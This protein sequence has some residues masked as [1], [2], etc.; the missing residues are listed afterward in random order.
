MSFRIL[1]GEIEH[2]ANTF[3]KVPTTLEGFRAG[4]LLLGDEIPA[5]RRG[6]RTALG[7]AFEAAEKFGWTLSHPLAAR[8]TPGGTVTKEAFEQ[9]CSWFL[10]GAGG[11]DGALINLHGAMV[12][13]GYEDAEGEILSRLRSVLGP[14][15]PIVVTLDLHANVTEKMA[16]N[17][18]AL[19]AVRTYPHIDYYER[20]WQGAELV[21][22]SLRGEIRPR[23]VIAKR[24]MLEG[25]DYGRTQVGPMRELIDRG[26]ALEAAGK[27]LV[28]SVCAGFSW[29]DISDV[30]PSVTVTADG[31]T[32]EAQRIAEG[33]MDHAW[34]TRAFVSTTD[35]TVSVAEALERA[36]AGEAGADKPLVIADMGD[37]P[38][39]GAY[40]DTTDLLR[41]M[42][43]ADLQNAAFHAIFDPAAVQAGIAIGVGNKGRILLGGKHAPEMGGGPLEVEAQIVSI[44]D[45]CFRCYGPSFLG[46]GAW[47]SFGPS[48]MLR[49]GGIEIAVISRREQTVD[50]AQLSSLGIDPFHCATIALKSYYHFRAAFEPIAREVIKVDAGGLGSAAGPRTYRHVRRPIWPLDDIQL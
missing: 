20:T 46:G 23:T 2:E 38:G 13:E 40:G 17:A 42:I 7:A 19:I 3:S 24:P 14:D 5:A 50:L 47:R 36:K 28:V 21:D 18:S 49:V 9:L 41:A 22:R 27:A 16:A 29:S 15:A 6:T 4:A 33:F 37:N 43:A 31:D 45:G 39:G 30:G 44:T 8:A 12:A 25:L 32:T 35:T 34:E 48:L 10:S 1:T 26:E 11:C